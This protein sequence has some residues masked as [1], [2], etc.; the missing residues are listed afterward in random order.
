M[1]RSEWMGKYRLHYVEYISYKNIWL[2]KQTDLG[3][4]LNVREACEKAVQFIIRENLTI[5]YNKTYVS[6]GWGNK[7]F[8]KKNYNI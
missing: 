7:F 8:A 2:A 5:D 4:C 3:Y 6:D 1:A